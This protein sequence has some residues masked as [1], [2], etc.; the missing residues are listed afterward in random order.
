M[1][2]RPIPQSDELFL[3]QKYRIQW[4]ISGMQKIFANRET[5]IMKLGS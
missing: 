1:G 5:L 4:F 2:N 3:L